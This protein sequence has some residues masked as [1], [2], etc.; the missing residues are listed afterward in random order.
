MDIGKERLRKKLLARQKRKMLEEKAQLEVSKCTHDSEKEL[1]QLNL[2]QELKLIENQAEENKLY[3]QNQFQLD[4]KTFFLIQ[5]L[6]RTIYPHLTI[7]DRLD[8][9]RLSVI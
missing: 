9:Y 4:Q 3:Y 6:L 1:I 2:D 7:K 5:Q 8:F